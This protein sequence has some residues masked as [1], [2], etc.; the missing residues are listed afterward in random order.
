MVVVQPDGRILTAG[1]FSEVNGVDRP[2]LARLNTDGSTDMSF[3]PESRDNGYR[4]N[5]LALQPD[6]KIL[7][8]LGDG[9]IVRLNADGSQDLTFD[10][11]NIQEDN[12]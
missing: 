9:S 12:V 4:V 8:A 11:R 2:G 6:H 7:A 5:A 1:A 3:L 10:F